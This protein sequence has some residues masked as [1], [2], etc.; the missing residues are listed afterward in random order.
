[1]AHVA[2]KPE[3]RHR[4]EDPDV[5]GAIIFKMGLKETGWVYT[6]LLCLGIRTDGCLL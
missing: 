4:S 2:G 5:D 6:L 3:G 1:M